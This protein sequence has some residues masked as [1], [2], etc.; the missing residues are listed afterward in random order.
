MSLTFLANLANAQDGAFVNGFEVPWTADRYRST[1]MVGLLLGGKELKLSSGNRVS[2]LFDGKVTTDFAESKFGSDY[3]FNAS[4]EMNTMTSYYREL[5]WTESILE[6]EIAFQS[7]GGYDASAHSRMLWSIVEKKNLNFTLGPITQMEEKLLRAPTPEMDDETA[8]GALPIKSMLCFLNEWKPSLGVVGHGV[9]PGF[10]SQQG[11][12]PADYMDPASPTTDSTD[13]DFQSQLAVH[14][15]GYTQAATGV[16]GSGDTSVAEG[17]LLEQLSEAV[18]FTKYDAIPMATM[19]PAGPD[20]PRMRYIMCSDAGYKFVERIVR[21]HGGDLFRIV[22]PGLGVVPTFSDFPLMP[23]PALRGKALY[24]DYSEGVNAVDAPL[25]TEG[26]STD[27]NAG[28]RFY[29]VDED[30]LHFF[31]HASR[32]WKTEPWQPYGIPKVDSIVRWGSAW[33]NLL[34]TKFRTSAIVYPTADIT[35]FSGS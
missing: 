6:H 25:V 12:L 2:Q 26:D 20:M 33:G 16:V 18:R 4:G 28:P 5:R 10:S 15:I 1:P 11:L 14:Q 19:S 35:G 22:R 17:H 31:C 32:A 9:P 21:A 24:P 23:V 30:A 29:L 13:D 27:G 7:G 3:V 34:M 8:E